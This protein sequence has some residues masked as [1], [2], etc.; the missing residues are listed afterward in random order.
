M[1][2]IKTRQ[3]KKA[4]RVEGEGV[5]VNRPDIDY[6]MLPPHMIEGARDYVENGLE[7]G[8]FLMAVLCND[9]TG[10]FGRADSINR[11]EMFTWASWLFN[12]APSPCWGSPAKVRAWILSHGE[13]DWELDASRGDHLRRMTDT[14]SPA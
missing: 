13:R 11:E 8:G 2:Q 6:S 5:T 4:S 3:S 14:L 12:E 10:A 1:R 7:P 9:L